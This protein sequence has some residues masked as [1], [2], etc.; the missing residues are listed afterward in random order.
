[1]DLSD[2]N[3]TSADLRDAHLTSANLSGLDLTSMD[4]TGANLVAAK[5][6]DA[7]LRGAHLVDADMRG[8][9]L[10]GAQLQHAVGLRLPLRALWNRETRWPAELESVVFERSD[11]VSPGLYRVR[12]GSAED[13]S[14]IVPV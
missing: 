1:M 4:L 5:L 10:T 6:R 3:L 8:A 11:E 12:S 7:R 13:R 9:D 2:A 14:G